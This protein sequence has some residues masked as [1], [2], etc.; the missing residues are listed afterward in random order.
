[1][2]HVSFNAQVGVQ[3]FFV[4]SGLLITQL[5]LAEHA[6]TG[7]VNLSRFYLRR[8]LRIFPVYYAAI[9]V[10]FT[11]VAA[12]IYGIHPLAFGAAITY[13]VNF[14]P[15][16]YMEATFSHF[17]SLAV[18]EHFYFF[19]PVAMVL[20]RGRV[21][22][23]GFF[24]AAGIALMILWSAYPP[25]IVLELARSHAVNR[26]TIP[27]ALPILVG[28]LTACLLWDRRLP[29][30]LTQA[31]GIAGVLVFLLPLASSANALVPTELQPLP[32]SVAIAAIMIYIVGSPRS[33]LVRSLEIRPLAY[34]GTISYGIYVWQG[35]F[36]G[37][38][39]YRQVSGWPPEPIVGAALA[40][41]V[42]ALSY[43]FLEAPILRY[44]DQLG[45]PARPEK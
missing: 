22:A 40:I 45:R 30:Y 31:A 8:V 39:P 35:I 25:P 23:A 7:R 29:P 42:A 16:D 37:N 38:G 13:V 9:A 4:L 6:F 32:S 33:V 41:S 19:W 20:A 1:V 44:K 26:W 11:L 15:W 34:L 21:R 5:T 17:W 14:A 36:T 10:S 28:C 24:A 3:I 12:G 43:R 2:L 27:A 18:E